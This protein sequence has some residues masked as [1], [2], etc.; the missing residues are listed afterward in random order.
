MQDGAGINLYNSFKKKY[1]DFAPSYMFGK[2][3]YVVSNINHIKTMLL[4]S[5]DLF[6]VGDLKKKFFKS[7]MAKNVGV[8][9]GCPWKQR[10]QMNE[11]ALV[12]DK[13]HVYAEDYNITMKQQIST[14]F[15]IIIIYFGI[16]LK[17]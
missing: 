15:Q 13:L 9:T 10:R 7:F 5:P 14:C 17:I 16:N 11:M 2:E 8:S 4:N 6:T 3:I 1:G 12:T